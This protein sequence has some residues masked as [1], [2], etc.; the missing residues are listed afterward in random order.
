MK[1]V[2]FEKYLHT[3]ACELVREGAKHSVFQNMLNG[4]L[5]TV[6]RHVELQPFLVRKICRDLGVEPPKEK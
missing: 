5:T 6:P 4:T 2:R 1:R 3:L